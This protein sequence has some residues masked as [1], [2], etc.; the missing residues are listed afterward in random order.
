MCECRTGS[1]RGLTP[2]NFQALWSFCWP[3]PSWPCWPSRTESRTCACSAFPQSASPPPP[4]EKES[5]QEREVKKKQMWLKSWQNHFNCNQ[6]AFPHPQRDRH[7]KLGL[8]N[9]RKRKTTTTKRPRKRPSYSL[10]HAE[11]EVNV[12]IFGEKEDEEMISCL[13]LLNGWIQA[14]LK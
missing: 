6:G 9:K 14:D 2:E 5:A 7:K 12:F 8:K 3:G 10:A 11:R 13:A 1:M 4:W